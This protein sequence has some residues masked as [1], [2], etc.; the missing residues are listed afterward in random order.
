[1]ILT[2]QFFECKLLKILKA[3]YIYKTKSL[4]VSMFVLSILYSINFKNWNQKL[5]WSCIKLNRIA[6]NIV[7]RVF[8][9]FAKSCEAINHNWKEVVGLSPYYLWQASIRWTLNLPNW[10]HTRTEWNTSPDVILVLLRSNH[11]IMRMLF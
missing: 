2:Y 9:N 1:M 7:C 6:V 10:W 5:F 11:A 4:K 3:K 8:K